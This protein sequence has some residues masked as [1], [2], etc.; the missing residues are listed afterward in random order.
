VAIGIKRAGA[1]L[2]AQLRN[3][4][5]FFCGAKEERHNPEWASQ[6]VPIHKRSGGLTRSSE[7]Y[8]RD[9]YGNIDVAKGLAKPIMS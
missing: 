3:R 2:T 5:N 8:P 4:R 7:R 6:R 1:L 9:V